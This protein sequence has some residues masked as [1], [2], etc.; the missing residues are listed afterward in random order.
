MKGP[1]LIELATGL[2]T[3]ELAVDIA[4]NGARIFNDLHAKGHRY[5]IKRF[6]SEL[7]ANFALSSAIVSDVVR[8]R[9]GRGSDVVR[10]CFGC[11]SEV[12]FPAFERELPAWCLKH[13]LQEIS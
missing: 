11:G 3:H 6:Q 7:E 2:G 4:V 13:D 1:K 5:T 12:A 9:F 10:M 8:M